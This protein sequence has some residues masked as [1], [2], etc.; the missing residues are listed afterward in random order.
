MKRRILIIGRGGREHALAWKIAQSEPLTDIFIAPGNAGTEQCGQNVDI[1]TDAT[2]QLIRFAMKNR[3]DLT[4]VGPD[5]PLAS[6]IVDA[7]EHEGLKIF[8]PCREAAKIE[9]S[10]AYAK[11][12]ML[13]LGIPTARTFIGRTSGETRAALNSFILP[14]VV[15]C[16]G[17]MAGKGVTICRTRSKAKEAITLAFKA[18]SVVLLEEFLDGPEVSLHALCDGARYV[19]L[20]LAQDHKYAN[21]GDTGLMTGGMGVVAPLSWAD[22]TFVER[23]GDQ[24]IAPILR[25]SPSL[26]DGIPFRGA[27]FAGLKLTKRGPRI[28]EYNARFGDPE[29]QVM[30][31]ILNANL[32]SLLIACAEGEL[33]SRFHG[34]CLPTMGSSACVVAVAKNYPKGTSEGAVIHGL[35]TSSAGTTMVFHAGTERDDRVVVTNGGRILCVTAFGQ[36]SVDI[37]RSVAYRRLSDLTFKGMRYRTDIGAKANQPP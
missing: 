2:A 33:P 22:T 14:V 35:D 9:W 26:N 4:V 20:P 30:L 1:R 5:Q 29:T 24:F 16:D 8:G 31:P 17:L 28:L 21:D 10:K 6:G 15:K 25:P 34:K 23:L 3:I 11:H 12:R 32:V 18:G 13:E 27:L 37:A 19:L 7:F 36:E